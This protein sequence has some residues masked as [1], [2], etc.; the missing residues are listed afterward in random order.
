MTKGRGFVLKWI[1]DFFELND[2]YFEL[3]DQ[4]LWQSV[5]GIFSKKVAVFIIE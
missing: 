4:Y 1:R 5:D 2:Q 3:N